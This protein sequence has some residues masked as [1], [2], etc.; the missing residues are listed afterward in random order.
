MLSC[1]NWSGT[2]TGK[3]GICRQQQ[4]RRDLGATSAS[5]LTTLRTLGSSVI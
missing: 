3:D 1:H 5:S 4:S 2:E